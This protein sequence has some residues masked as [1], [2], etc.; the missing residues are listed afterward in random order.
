M[1]SWPSLA[2]YTKTEHGCAIKP[3][4]APAFA[5]LYFDD[6]AGGFS[7]PLDTFSLELWL[8]RRGHE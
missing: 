4:P 1:T 8:S 7:H 3:N 5:G 2:C 6:T